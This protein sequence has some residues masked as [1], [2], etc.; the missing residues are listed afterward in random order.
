M[1]YDIT[2][3][4]APSISKLCKGTECIQI[5]LL[6]ASKG[7]K[8]PLFRSFIPPLAQKRAFGNSVPRPP[9]EGQTL[10]SIGVAIEF[11]AIYKGKLTI[12]N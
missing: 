6:Q 8:E 1:K 5:L 12:G 11:R 3:G 9:L 10:Y 4:S 2:Q 7:M